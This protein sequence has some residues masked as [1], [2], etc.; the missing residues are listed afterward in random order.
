VVEMSVDVVMP[1]PPSHL[2][3]NSQGHQSRDSQS[4]R[5]TRVVRISS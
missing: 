2:N 1:S 4:K 3:I 5:M